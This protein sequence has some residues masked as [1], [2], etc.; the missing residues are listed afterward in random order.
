MSLTFLAAIVSVRVRARV[1]EI[2][3]YHSAKLCD[4]SCLAAIVC[5]RVRARVCEIKMHRS[6]KLCELSCFSCE[7]LFLLRM[8]YCNR[9][10]ICYSYFFLTTMILK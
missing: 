5:V 2:K 9:L 1:C 10:R 8:L 7:Y 6:A 4:L 3:M